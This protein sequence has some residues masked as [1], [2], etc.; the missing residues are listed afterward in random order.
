MIDLFFSYSH[1]DEAMRNE[2]EV[3]LSMLKRNGL[4]RAWHDRRI[5]AG[6]DLDREISEH[7]ERADVILLLLSPHFLASD[8][9]YETE[10][11]RAL[12]RHDERTA[13]VIPVIL[14]PCDWLESPFRKLRA[15]PS[16]GKPIAKFPN[17][18]DAFLEVA[19]DI[20]A[21]A[22]SLNK[23]EVATPKTVAGAVNPDAGVRSS[24]LRLKKTFTDRDRDGFRDEAFS[25][26]DK[27]FENSL[28]ELRDRNPG[29]EFRFKRLSAA[30]FTA[31]VYQGGSKMTSC[32]VWLA[33]GMS[34]GM[35]IAYSANDSIATNSINDGLRIDD[36]GFQLGLKASGLGFARPTGESLMTPHG[37]A[38]YLWSSFISRLQ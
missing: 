21:A 18:N 10:A 27:F 29:I 12:Q 2:L 15:T 13:V 25:Y 3:H 24:N 32:H 9:C 31:A 26:I 5:T 20:R 35:D 28:G 33:E 4:V 23:A 6:S 1:H 19:R 16:D 38:E 36:D 34:F 8:Y 22:V 7:L 11:Q 17:V 30:G 14:Q 37:A